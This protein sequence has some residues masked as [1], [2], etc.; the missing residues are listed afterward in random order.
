MKCLDLY[1]YNSPKVGSIIGASLAA[2]NMKDTVLTTGGQST[3]LQYN[4][5]AATFNILTN[6]RIFLKINYS[7]RLNLEKYRQIMAT[8]L[9]KTFKMTY[10]SSQS[11]M[12]ERRADLDKIYFL[13][14]YNTDALRYAR[15]RFPQFVSVT[16]HCSS[17]MSA[18]NR[19]VLCST[20]VQAICQYGDARL[21]SERTG[22]FITTYPLPKPDDH[23]KAEA[24]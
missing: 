16:C 24:L 23:R 7:K 5:A 8:A 20:Q 12:R 4:T 14:Y 15:N 1:L 17:K 3:L 21:K 6:G 22:I 19:T 9:V 2:C 11:D 10:H 18:V 13:A